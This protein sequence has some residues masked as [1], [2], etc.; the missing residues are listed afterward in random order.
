MKLPKPVC[1]FHGIYYISSWSPFTSMNDLKSQYGLV[2]TSII[3]CGMKLLVITYSCKRGSW[4]LDPA[5]GFRNI[6]IHLEPRFYQI[7]FAHNLLFQFSRQ[8]LHRVQQWYCHALCKFSKRF[9]DWNWRNGWTWFRTIWVWKDFRM[10]ILYCNRAVNMLF[11]RLITSAKLPFVRSACDTPEA[12]LFASSVIVIWE[13]WI[14]RR[15]SWWRHQ[16]R[17]FSAL[18]ALCGGGGGDPLVTSVFLSQ[19]PVTRSFD[20][21][22]DLRRTNGWAI[23]TT[24]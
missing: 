13:V 1:I 11:L 14:I 7:S 2:T 10:D 24:I 6:G 9:G 18:L 16:M 22:F 23:V 3:K 21:F 4:L 20:V 12:D 19:R 8:I 5:G 15:F 17:I